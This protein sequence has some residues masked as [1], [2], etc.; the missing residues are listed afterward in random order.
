MI[1]RM[2]GSDAN[3]GLTIAT[4][5]MSKSALAPYFTTFSLPRVSPEITIARPPGPARVVMR[6]DIDHQ[7]VGFEWFEPVVAE[8]AGELS[9]KSGVLVHH[10]SQPVLTFGGCLDDHHRLLDSTAGFSKPAME[11]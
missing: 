11:G 5:W 1:R 6:N 2:K 10:D 8:G 4:S 9:R 7:I 3:S